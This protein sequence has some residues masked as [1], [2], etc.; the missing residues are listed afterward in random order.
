MQCYAGVINYNLNNHDSCHTYRTKTF[1]LEPFYRR[2]RALRISLRIGTVGNGDVHG[3]VHL[4]TH[5]VLDSLFTL[6]RPDLGTEV[7]LDGLLDHRHRHLDS[8]V[9]DAT[10]VREGATFERLR[11]RMQV[12]VEG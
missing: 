2:T 6:A 4:A 7:M 8:D 12:Q 10:D 9:P 11:S 3:V 5:E 1:Y